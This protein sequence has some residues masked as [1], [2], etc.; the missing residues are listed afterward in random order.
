MKGKVKSVE[1]WV[2]RDPCKACGV[3]NGIGSL[4]RELGVEEIIVHSPLGTQK[5]YPPK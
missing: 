5:F 1:M 3:N 4:A 2:D